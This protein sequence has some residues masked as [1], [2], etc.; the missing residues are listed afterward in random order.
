MPAFN[1]GRVVVTTLWAQ[2][3]PAAVHFYRDGLGL[4]PVPHHGAYPSFELEGSYLVILQGQPRPAENAKPA[5]FPLFALAVDDLDRAVEHL[6]AHGVALPWGI[7]GHEPGR[8]VM[9]HDPAGNL[10]ELVQD[11]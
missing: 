8:Y 7:E 9:F 6:R 5:R 4:Q 3:V 1:V 11:H 10:I 2:D